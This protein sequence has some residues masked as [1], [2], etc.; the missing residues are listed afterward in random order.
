MNIFC[1]YMYASYLFVVILF[2]YL[3]QMTSQ[4][5]EYY[6]RWT[7]QLLRL[8]GPNLRRDAASSLSLQETLRSL[9][10]AIKIHETETLHACEENLHLLQFIESQQTLKL[11]QQESVS[12]ANR[13]HHM[14]EEETVD[15]SSPSS[16]KTLEFKHIQ[17][18]IQDHGLDKEFDVDVS[19][20]PVS[21]YSAA[22][23]EHTQTP[24]VAQSRIKKSY[25]E[26]HVK[27]PSKVDGHELGSKDGEVFSSSDIEGPWASN[28]HDDDDTD[29]ANDM[30]SDGN[31][32]TDEQANKMLDNAQLPVI[33]VS[34]L[35]TEASI[36][37]LKAHVSLMDVGDGR[38]VE[39]V[40]VES[41]IKAKRS[42]QRSK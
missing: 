18:Y 34:K 5:I 29:P 17:K 1:H 11:S 6:L 31:D 12:E 22:S 19:N 23:K 37:S 35:S 36:K 9:L 33:K 8:Y 3:F 7:W 24:A 32:S 16:Y 20:V 13:E 42:Q 28:W 41:V 26:D 27:T 30:S 39:V 21:S 15:E 25:S 14:N 2:Q 4:Q 38:Q 40:D 10:R